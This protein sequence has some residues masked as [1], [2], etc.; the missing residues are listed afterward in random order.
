[1]RKI[2]DFIINKR[3]FILV[4]FIILTIISGLLASKVKINHDIAKYLPDTSSTRIGMDIME[5]EFSENETSTLNLMFEDLPQEEKI[6]VKNYLE[7]I[8]G[9]KSVEHEDTEEYN[10]ENY[11]L[12]VISVD[13]KS[14]SKKATEV[15]NQVIDNYKDYTIYTSGNVSE[16]NKTVL[17]IW[18]V[19]LAIA[20]ALVIL[21]I[22]CESYAEPFL[23]L[24]AILMAVVLNKGTNIIFGTVSNITD[25][26]AAILQLALSMDYSIMLMNRYE[27]EKATEKDKVKAMKNALYRAFQAISSS[28]VTTI[29]GLLALVFM[30]FKIGR[31]L[32]F[33][34]AKGVLFSLICIFFVLPALI[35][36]FDKLI[37]KTK[38]K[39]PNIK[40]N[41]LGK[42]SYKMRY[43]AVPLF[44]IVFVESFLLKGNLGIDYTDQQQDKISEIFKENNQMA[45]IYKND[46]EEKI[47]KYLGQL[48]D[49]EDV[50]E[51]LGYGNTIGE[52]LPYDK[53]NEKL[54]DLGSD[55][56]IE[57]YLLKILYYNYYN[58][59][60]NSK[61]TFNEFINFIED[62]AYNNEKI[63]KEIDENT[64][65]DIT[66]LKNFVQESL[67]NK[68][69]T[70]VDLANILEIDKNQVDDMLTYYLSK[71]ENVK[72]TLKDFI[73]FM[74]KEVLTDNKY[75]AKV[76][77]NSKNSL[78][79]LSKFTNKQTIQNKMTSK[80]I[81]NLFE[82]DL[83]MVND[84][85]KYYI[86]INDIN[87][88]LT[89]S[90]FSNYVLNNVLKDTNYSG[91]FDKETI[92]NINQLA[93]FS[94]VSLIN[95]DM[96]SNELSKLFSI[97]ENIVKKL[98]LLKYSNT[99]NGTKLTIPEFINQVIFIKN[100]TDYIKDLDTTTLQMLLLDEKVLNNPNKYT[101]EELSSIL[102]IEKTKMY[103]IY[104][105]IDFI[106]GNTSN[107]K[108][109]PN[110]FV[111]FILKNSENEDVKSN[112][113][114]EVTSKLNLLAKVMSSSINKTTYSYLDLSKTIGIDTMASK[115]IYTLYIYNSN[116]TKLTPQEFVNF[117]LKHKEDAELVNNINASTISDLTKVQSV[118]N[119]VISN[120]KYTSQEMSSLLGINNE[121]LKL[122]YGL[123]NFKN[124]NKNPTISLKDFIQFMLN[125][126]ITN[127]EYSKYFDEEKI[128]KLTTVNAIMNNSLNNTLY[129][130]DEI[131]VILSKL[132]DSV[133]KNTI[134]ILYTYYGS[135]K[136]YN[137]DWK[138]TV[139][140]FVKYLNE[141]ILQ[142]ERYL[143]FIE[144]D[145][146]QDIIDAKQQIIDAKEL[147][148]GDKYSRIVLN[149]N[150][151]AE[152]NE[153]FEFI[154]KVKDMLGNDINNFYVIGDSPMAYEMSQTFDNELNFIT[155]I[156][157]VAIFI[158]VAITFKSILIPI[159]LVL[160]IQCAVYLT[161]G[162]ISFT[163]E[164][165]YFIAILIVQSILMGATIDYAI[166]Y[167]SYYLENRKE[168]GIKDAI[169]ESYNKS[170]HTI[171]TSS[172]ILIIVTLI[173]ANFASAIAAKICKT[174]SQGTLCST[175]LILALLP[176]VLAMCDRIIIKKE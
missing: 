85:Y 58:P 161:M 60:N 146:R 167:T 137:N 74:N 152:T 159:I 2:T 45:I 96:S 172:S 155:I 114:E 64:R 71:N 25:S 119:G 116:L 169:I 50:E 55:V 62:E 82:I 139:E 77:K 106:Q 100:N 29:V 13:D 33:V 94:N 142:D 127:D 61:M 130:S 171:L 3:H 80:Q 31:D 170:I 101:A 118:M 18:I 35:L 109:S 9:V 97:D 78:N 32:G 165:V 141:D 133:E 136:Q 91:S 111:N 168:K 22:M 38:K 113:N 34:L 67:I 164:N 115:N 70:G 124:I 76:D 69:R 27:Q 49:E 83:S 99:D 122:I 128:S 104:A 157:M 132:S 19:I 166:L 107:W 105:L 87:L 86:S 160:T 20:C 54:N 148:I 47:E 57:D 121:D 89:I 81:A 1:M 140:E 14:D 36:M 84:L 151:K 98:L 110:E 66:R 126:I 79:T 102:N 103:S 28:S 37:T 5:E 15:Y 16:T 53:L 131:F 92:Q 175:I 138:I 108:M 88:K 162:I 176:A 144:D 52:K 10:K 156:T 93:T 117:I 68:K 134:E 154:Q 4:I 153:T 112:I 123:Y 147:I 72:I 59:E 30:S 149:T 95:K 173:I 129:S 39:S 90:E 43:I 26:I 21:I 6:E 174:I 56:E 143:D 23:F 65:K 46:E 42:F 11:T 44:L 40:L 125:D 7:K 120:K 145:M 12:Y 17:S 48:E 135:N 163:G 158:V 63:S 24:T 75:S 150:F 41:W 51:V 8:D 73:N